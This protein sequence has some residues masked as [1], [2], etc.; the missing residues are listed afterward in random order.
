M[1]FSEARKYLLEQAK[2]TGLDAEILATESRNLSLE[3]FEQK[4][5]QITQATQGGIGVRVVKNGKTGYASTEERSQVA[6]DW[7][8][9]E[10]AENAELQS[11]EGGF[12]PE[13]QVLGHKDLI[14][15]GLSAPIEEKAAAAHE[16]EAGLRQDER[17][18]QVPLTRYSESESEVSLSSTQGADGG[19]RNG[20]AF[21]LSSLIMRQ[22]DSLKQV[23]D[24]NLEK[25][26][27]ALEPGKTAL[28]MIDK[29]ARMLGAKPLKT[30]RYRSYF[31]PKAFA[32]LMGLFVFML[33]GKTVLEGKSRFAD[34]IGEKVASELF[35]LV[36]DPLLPGGK[37]NRPFDSEGT[38]A[39]TLRLIENGVLKRFMHNSATAQALGHNNTGHAQRSYKSTLGVGPSNLFVEPGSGVTLEQGVVITDLMGVHAGANPI[40]GDFSLQAFGLNVEGGEV[41]HPIENFAVSGN[42]LELLMNI[43][44]IGGEL[45]WFPYSGILGAPMV[46]VAEL[47]FAGE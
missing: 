16:L 12:L 9:Q 39:Q 44:G 11:D 30:G 45:E 25:E 24:F 32:Q 6:L 21:L 47:S 42:L 14:G 35:T 3:S 18:D 4:L 19:Y 1:T 7:V 31:E 46:E 8:L 23:Y 10:A 26:F 27:H 37:G 28:D 2:S 5:A 34:K 43:T 33:S 17:T 22:D 38:P 20:Y 40:S 29:T 15:E 36:D 13:G 41:K